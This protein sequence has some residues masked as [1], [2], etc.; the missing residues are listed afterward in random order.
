MQTSFFL[1]EREGKV[2]M[3]QSSTGLRAIDLPIKNGL[4][5]I[6]GTKTEFKSLVQD[7]QE[8]VINAPDEVR[9]MRWGGEENERS[10]LGP[11]PASASS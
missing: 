7:L 9:N 6:W 1:S 5:V 4:L 3:F 10:P 11:Q 8:Q 2:K